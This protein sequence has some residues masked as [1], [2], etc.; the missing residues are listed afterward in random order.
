MREELRL[1]RRQMET[2]GM[3]AYL[4]VSDDDHASEY[5][6]D[7]YKCRE[8]ISGFNG[9]AGTLV[10]LPGEAGL[11]T[12][13]RY[14]IQ[15][16]QQLAG[17]GIDLYR[18]GNEGVPTL[19]EFLLEKLPEGAVLGFDGRTVSTA[20]GRRL[21]QK[22]AERRIRFETGK[23]L[24]DRIW[25]ERP[26]LPTN[27]AWLLDESYAGERCREKLE[28]LREELRRERADALLVSALDE[29]AWLLNVRG[30][31]IAYCPV[32]L[33]FF[34]LEQETA[35][36]YVQPEALTPQV[37]EKMK[38]AG[39]WC[40]PYQEVYER[41]AKLPPGMVLLLDDESTNYALYHAVSKEAVKRR[42]PSPI[43]RMKAVKNAA[44]LCNMRLAHY[45]DGLA[46]TRLIY[47]LKT[48]ADKSSLTELDVC[49]RLEMY[50]SEGEHYLE[51][52]FAPI[53]AYGA[54]GAIVHYEPDRKTDIPLGNEGFLLLDTGG[55]YL[56]GTTDVTRTIALGELTRE[57]KHHYTAVLKGNLH[58]GAAVFKHG[59]T[60]VNLDYLAR[61]AL[62]REGLD[63]NHG[64]GH[65]VGY[66]LNVHEGPNA[67]RFRERSGCGAVLEEGMITSNEPGLYLE[68]R[69]GIRLEN[70]IL[71]RKKLANE[72]GTFLEFETLTLVPFDMDAVLLEELTP[73]E[74]E[75]LR[76][77]QQ[78]VYDTLKG[79]LPPEVT[80]WLGKQV[81][82]I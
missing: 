2:E 30:N 23:D 38:E 53:A 57:Q 1:L 59:C 21:T 4:I 31:D 32:V 72:Y 19:E 78:R 81:E 42:K 7:Y 3:D 28:R 37:E 56:E 68:G 79:D 12:D 47:W 33:S 22:L 18:S 20:M 5:V 66:L 43:Q 69:Y 39:V 45:K 36:W 9:S 46:L 67:I 17:S 13:G 74:R 48:T 58:L 75:L 55:H 71:C 27:Q 70:L 77:Y 51:Q 25:K 76:A 35:Y 10:V 24:C 14:F 6:G 65:G 15:A 16:D 50:R 49:R 80:E 61:A 8:F 11:W 62:W 64:T 52:S 34:L 82:L 44:E 60:G 29:I 54:H 40:R 41:V 26:K 63:Y 73:G